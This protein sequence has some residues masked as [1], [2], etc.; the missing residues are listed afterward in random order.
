MNENKKRI[1]YFLTILST[2]I[3]WWYWLFV[4]RNKK[5]FSDIDRTLFGQD[6][7]DF[8]KNYFLRFCYAMNYQH[9]F[10]SNFYLRL[11]KLRFIRRILFWFYPPER[12][13]MIH[14]PETKIGEGLLLGHGFSIMVIANEI[15][16][17]CSIFQQVTVGFT[18]KGC[19]TIGNNVS[20]Y[21]GAKV[22]GPVVIGDNAVIGANAVVTRDVPRNAIVAGVPARIIRIKESDEFVM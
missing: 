13:V 17:N 11:G 14:M 15:G 10:V 1:V 5:I 7:P 8:K 4:K 2:I 6:M 9:E 20:I 19:P 21:A 18:R 12:T 16:K 22:L 3:L